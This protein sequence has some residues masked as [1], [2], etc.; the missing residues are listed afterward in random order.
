MSY[1]GLEIDKSKIE[2]IENLPYP[3]LVKGVRNC[4]KYMGY[5]RLFIKDFS[6]IASIMYQI[7]EKEVNL[8]F[9]D[10]F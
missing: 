10:E 2:V 1:R 3:M 9:G 6:K 4:L 5:Y 7:L 8:N